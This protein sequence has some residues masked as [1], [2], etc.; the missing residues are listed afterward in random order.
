MISI[1]YSCT[2]TPIITRPSSRH[3]YTFNRSKLKYNFLRPCWRRGPDPLPTLILILWSPRSLHSYP[4][5]IWNYF[6]CSYLLLWKKRT[7]WVHGNGVS[8]NIYWL[9]RI[10]CMS[11]SHIYSR[12]RRRHTS[13]LYICHYN[14]CNSYRRKSIQ[15]TCNS[16]RR[17]Y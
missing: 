14:H 15:L 7:I 10:H 8:H 6:T 11:T 3:Y 9:P 4:S 1:N 2:S 16:T 17:K 5:R 13:L 12:P